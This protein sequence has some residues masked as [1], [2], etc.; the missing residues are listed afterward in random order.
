[1]SWEGGEIFA[2]DQELLHGYNELKKILKYQGIVDN[3]VCLQFPTLRKNP[4][5]LLFWI[6][7]DLCDLLCH[8]LN[9]KC[10]LPWIFPF[11]AWDTYRCPNRGYYISHHILGWCP[12]RL[13]FP[14]WLFPKLLPRPS[15][16]K[17][18]FSKTTAQA[19]WIFPSFSLSLLTAHVYYPHFANIFSLSGLGLP[20]SVLCRPYSQP[21]AK[22]APCSLNKNDVELAEK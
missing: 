2:K 18:E 5:S 1:M 16:Q 21:A 22:E 19:K 17:R 15:S 20:S 13:L 9:W 11:G 4:I 14:F 3:Y 8:R 7:K 6:Q 10:Y 12:L